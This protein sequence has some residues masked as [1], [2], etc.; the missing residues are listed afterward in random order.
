M[1]ADFVGGLITRSLALLSDAARMFTDSAALAVSLVALWIA[2]RA[3]DRKR[4][5]GS[6]RLEILAAAFNRPLAQKVTAFLC[7]R[8]IATA[9]NEFPLD[10]VPQYG[11]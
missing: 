2:K 8:V 5:F 9:D 3:A 10:T 7:Q 1:V 6:Y 4:A 11:R